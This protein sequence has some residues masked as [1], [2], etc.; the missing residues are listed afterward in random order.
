MIATRIIDNL[1]Q[2]EELWPGWDALA[3]E[4]AMPTAA[5]A[6]MLSWWKHLAPAGALLRI[7][8][9]LEGKCLIGIAP[10]YC[11]A[12]RRGRPTTYRLLAADFSTSVGPLA[13]ADRTWEVGEA[14]GRALAQSDPQPDM[15][16]LEPM[17][18]VTP[19]LLALRDGWPSALRPALRRYDVQS[20]P[21]VSLREDSFEEWFQDRS[22][23][24][25]SNTRRLKRLA[26]QEGATTR[27]STPQ[28]LRADAESFLR[29]HALRW[30]GKG[31]RLTALG[32]RLTEMLVDVGMGLLSE[33][34]E[35]T[36]ERGPRFRMRITEVE[37]EAVCVD[38]SIA[39]GGEIVGFNMGWDERFKR[40]SPAL[41]AFLNEIADGFAFGDRRVQLGWGGNTYKLRFANGDDPVAWSLLLLPGH[42]LPIAL[43]R[44]A[45]LTTSAWA[46]NHG[47]RLL[48]AEQIER[49][50]PLA[51]LM[52]R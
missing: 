40:F 20:M 2:A 3:C 39:G 19:W 36:V 51:R 22:A 37:G 29:L 38:I 6:W 23:K 8:A 12:P 11:E 27:L 15:L 5:P 33:R 47:K 21:V 16:A 49:I 31:S 48:N 35:S 14:I 30:E 1:E 9:V 45:P 52:P 44:T 18:F 42:R 17:P 41:L 50:R 34:H 46:R 13:R 25:R 7:V 43:A 32:E 4:N 26:E 10:L 24:F 28:T